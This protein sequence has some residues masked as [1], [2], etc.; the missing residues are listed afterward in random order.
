ME[1]LQISERQIFKVI[2]NAS[3]AKKTKRKNFANTSPNPIPKRK[4]ETLFKN[5][6]LSDLSNVCIVND[7]L[8]DINIYLSVSNELKMSNLEEA[9]GARWR[10]IKRYKEKR[11]RSGNSFPRND[12]WVN[13]KEIKPIS[14]FSS[15]GSASE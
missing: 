5:G 14:P 11:M 15:T 8:K 6:R 13:L 1:E 4:A 2:Y 9:V 10:K 12:F 3:K 7:V